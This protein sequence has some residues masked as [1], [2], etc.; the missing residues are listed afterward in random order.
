MLLHTETPRGSVTVSP[1]MLSLVERLT[2]EGLIN[3]GEATR[4]FGSAR[5]TTSVHPQTIMRWIHKGTKVSG[6]VV[7]LEAIK[8]GSQRWATSKQA[9]HRFIAAMQSA[10]TPMPTEVPA[11]PASMM[12]RNRADAAAA[13][14]LEQLGF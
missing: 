14:E 10:S 3:V 8:I 4:V 7:K 13:K 6:R 2:S 11:M 5:S 12:Q 9:I 1:E